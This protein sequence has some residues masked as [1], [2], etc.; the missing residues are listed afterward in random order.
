MQ[1]SKNKLSFG[2]LADRTEAFYRTCS[3]RQKHP[4]GHVQQDTKKP[5]RTRSTWLRL[6]K[7]LIKSEC[8][9]FMIPSI[10]TKVDKTIYNSPYQQ[11]GSNL[12]FLDK[13]LVYQIAGRYFQENLSEFKDFIRV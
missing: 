9:H 5:Y 11:V 1:A 2:H 12:E 3:T 6:L 7:D 10:D 13:I 4:I 8:S